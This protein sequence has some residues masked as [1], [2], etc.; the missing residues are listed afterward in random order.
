MNFIPQFLGQILFFI[1]DK[2]AFHNYGVA[3]I[4]FTIFIK[5]ALLPL[6]IKQYKSTA[7]MQELQPLMQ[8]IQRKYKNDK[9]KQTQEMM[10]MYQEHKYN[11]ASGCLPILVQMPILFSLIYVIGKPLTYML[12]KTAEEIKT[13]IDKVPAPDRIKGFYEQIPAAP[14]AGIDLEFLGLNLGLVPKFNPSDLF[15]PEMAQYLPLLIIPILAV[16]TTYL[17]T[18]MA[19]PRLKNNKNNANDMSAAMQKNMMLMAPVMTLFV[20]FQFP[21]G[22]GLYWLT[23]NVFQ[24]VQQFFI[25][26]FIMKKKEA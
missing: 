20:S 7:K 13:L 18:K 6:T 3:I 12:G 11:P 14:Q 2:L 21:A 4:L 22:L 25:N 1:Y 19:T 16:I 23:G 5:L 24:I 8:E 17:S 26:K 9:E 10:K 15:G